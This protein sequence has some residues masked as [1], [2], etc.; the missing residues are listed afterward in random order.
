MLVHLHFNTPDMDT[1][2][3]F[4][5]MHVS[6]YVTD[7]QKSEAFY[8]AFFQ[9]QPVKQKEDYLKYVLE[10]PS[11]IIS[12]VQKP[13]KVAGNFG[14]LGFQVASVEILKEKL[15]AAYRAKLPVIEE[16]GTTCCYALQDKF[17]VADPDGY[18]WEVYV[19]HEDAVFEDPNEPHIQ[20]MDP[21]MESVSASGSCCT[22]AVGSRKAGATSCC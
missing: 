20:T 10:A 9:T 19:F 5:R 1:N 15:L 22:P 18:H 8:T 2:Q 3:S 21:P 11:L 4:P 17:W 16:M 6:L 14:H 13:E 12:F 7:I